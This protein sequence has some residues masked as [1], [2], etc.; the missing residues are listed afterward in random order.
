MTH[1][2]CFSFVLAASL[3]A[4]LFLT[5]GDAHAQRSNTRGIFLNAHLNATGIGYDDDDFDTQSGGGLGV[6]FGY[7]VSNLVTLFLGVDGAV[8]SS[9]DVEDAFTLA[10]VDAGAQFN[11]GRPRS[12]ARPYGVVALTFRQATFDLGEGNQAFEVDFS[13]GGLTLGGGLKYFFSRVAALDVG[14]NLTFGQFNDVQVGGVTVQ[15]ALDLNATSGRFVVGL[16]WF[17]S[18]R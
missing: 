12:A 7:G 9:D 2:N 11:F 18:R 8:M 14:L 5:T 15:N 6:Q 1:R 16:S 4:L 13:G 10:H 3:T 17:P